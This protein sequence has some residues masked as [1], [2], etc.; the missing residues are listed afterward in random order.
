MKDF[1]RVFVIGGGK[2]GAAMAKAVE[3]VLGARI[4]GGLLNVKYG[5]TGRLKH[6][7]LNE[8]GHHGAG[9]GRGARGA[10]DRRDC[11]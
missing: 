4:T 9:R 3:R 10:R 5:H 6:I 11:E 1:D 2:A 8:C 7:R